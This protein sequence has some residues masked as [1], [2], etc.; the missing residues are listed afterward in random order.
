MKILPTNC[1]GLVLVLLSDQ[2]PLYF[3]N[4]YSST[5]YIAVPFCAYPSVVV[6]A[7]RPPPL[8]AC[9]PPP[10]PAPVPTPISKLTVKLIIKSRA[11]EL[12]LGFLGPRLKTEAFASNLVALH[13]SLYFSSIDT[14]F[15]PSSDNHLSFCIVF[16][17]T[18]VSDDFRRNLPLR[19]EICWNKR[20]L[21]I[22]LLFNDNPCVLM[23]VSLS[24]WWSLCPDDGLSVLMMVSLS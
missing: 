9:V 2:P 18:I 16:I 5:I 17:A 6:A 8:W 24:W 1:F 12:E 22:Y 15:S 19:I 23:M 20:I 13:K 14:L 7:L 21:F 10:S 3:Q 11:P 4:I